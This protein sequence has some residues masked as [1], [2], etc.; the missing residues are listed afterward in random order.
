MVHSDVLLDVVDVL[1]QGAPPG[2]CTHEVE[3]VE[4]VMVTVESMTC[5][6]VRVVV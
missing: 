5:V 4:G 2:P 1:G 3:P 6:L